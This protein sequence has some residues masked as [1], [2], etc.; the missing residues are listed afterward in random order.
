MWGCPSTKCLAP[1]QPVLW[2]RETH[3][4]QGVDGQDVEPWGRNHETSRA[5]R[6]K[7]EQDRVPRISS[8][9]AYAEK[10]GHCFLLQ[11]AWIWLQL[12]LCLFP[13]L[14]YF[15]R[16]LPIHLPSPEKTRTQALCCSLKSETVQPTQNTSEPTVE[17][18][19][20]YSCVQSKA[21]QTDYFLAVL[22]V[23]WPLQAP[24][25]CAILQRLLW[26][27]NK[28]WKVKHS[29]LCLAQSRP[30]II[31]FPSSDS[32]SE[33]RLESGS[34]VLETSRVNQSDNWDFENTLVG[35]SYV[36]TNKT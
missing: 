33:T 29:L 28:P 32:N 13:G 23:A 3:T 7:L 9:T 18:Q 6:D 22:Q 14:L 16:I 15:L 8:H 30:S 5:G 11:E 10:T 17:N 35:F 19:C 21:A 24:M 20:T 27:L 26:G 2:K 4:E 25:P 12:W 31:S 34:S 36:F 1:Y